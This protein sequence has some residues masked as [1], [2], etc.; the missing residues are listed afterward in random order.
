MRENT[1]VK[2]IACNLVAAFITNRNR[3]QTFAND[4]IANCLLRQKTQ[5]V[6]L[7]VSE[8]FNLGNQAKKFAGVSLN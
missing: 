7:C 5:C 4:R 3:E 6:L 1:A 2:Q 8:F